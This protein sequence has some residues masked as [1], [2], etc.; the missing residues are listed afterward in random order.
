MNKI[1]KILKAR[2][3]IEALNKKQDKI[4]NKT[5]DDLG[6]CTPDFYD[7]PDWLF[8]YLYNGTKHSL[9]NIKKH[10]QKNAKTL[11]WWQK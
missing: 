8:D 10:L 1:D 5:L 9:V 11:S 2:K 6:G 7:L 4:F 3:K